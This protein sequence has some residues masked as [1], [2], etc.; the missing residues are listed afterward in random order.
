MRLKHL[1]PMVGMLVIG[2]LGITAL[3]TENT[4]SE[5]E[6]NLLGGAAFALFFIC[7][8]MYFFGSD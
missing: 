4:I 1:V 5:M 8:V 3:I 6:V 7:F 2:A